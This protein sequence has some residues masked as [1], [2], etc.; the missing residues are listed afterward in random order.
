[1]RNY[2]ESIAAEIDDE[3]N[4]IIRSSYE[5]TQKILNDHIDKLHLVAN[6]LL[7]KEKIDGEE[8][9]RLM[10]PDYSEPAK[11]DNTFE[12]EHSSNK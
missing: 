7:K 9:K 12:A 11:E 6:V 5:R 8:F 4:K 1:M 3:V 2:S 10:D